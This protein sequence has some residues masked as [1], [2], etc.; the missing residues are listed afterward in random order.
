[1]RQKVKFLK[2]KS[3]EGREGPSVI[4]LWISALALGKYGAVSVGLLLWQAT[5]LLLFVSSVSIRGS[6]M[7]VLR[8]SETQRYKGI[9]GIC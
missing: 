4:K 2:W 3:I 5:R 8:G 1:M 7:K 6:I 9:F